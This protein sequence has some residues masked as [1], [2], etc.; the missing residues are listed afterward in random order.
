MTQTSTPQT[1]RQ[2]GRGKTIR[3]LLL[4]IAGTI[5]GFFLPFFAPWTEEAA[6]YLIYGILFWLHDRFPESIAFLPTRIKIASGLFAGIYMI[7][8]HL[9]ILDLTALFYGAVVALIG[10]GNKRQALIGAGLI[11]AHLGFTGYVLFRRM[12]AILN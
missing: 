10:S 1:D 6:E 7:D 2:S 3:W 12:V 8:Q 11:I 4:F 5:A 9:L